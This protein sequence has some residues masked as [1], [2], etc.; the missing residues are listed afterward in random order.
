MY[1]TYPKKSAHPSMSVGEQET[2]DWEAQ[3]EST[4]GYSTNAGA[5]DTDY[6]GDK[7]KTLK[8]EGGSGSPAKATYPKTSPRKFGTEKKV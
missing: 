5:K 8:C 3:P 2:G 1:E 6:N 7:S 4:T